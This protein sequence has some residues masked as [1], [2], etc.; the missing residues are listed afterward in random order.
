MLLSLIVLQACS[1]SDFLDKKP[2][3]EIVVANTLTDFTNLL[4]NTSILRN[5]GGLAQMGSDDYAI[6]TFAEWQSLPSNTQRNSYIWNRDIYSGDNG[7]QDWNTVYRGIFYANAVL[8]GL[9]KSPES[10]SDLGLSIK[11]RAL[12]VRSYA[13]YDL[14]RNFCKPYDAATANQDLGIPLRLTAA[15]EQIE[16]R[17]SLQKSFDQI[18]SDLGEAELL[19]PSSRPSS[20]LNRPSKIAVYALLS[21]IYL[22]M[23]KYDLAESNADK[24]LM[25]YNKLIDYNTLSKT[26]TMPFSVTNDE[27]IYNTMQVAT[28]SE[29]TGAG[30]SSVARVAKEL[31]DLY[32]PDDLRIPIYFTYNAMANSYSI[33]RG[34]YGLGLYPFTGLATDEIYLIKAECLARNNKFGPAMDKLN[35]LL[36]KRFPNSVANPYIPIAATSSSEALTK[37]LNER[38][39]EL[40]WRGLRWHDLKRLNKEGAN[41]SLNR[42]LNGKTYSLPPNDPRWI[43]PIPDDE[44]LL[45]GIQQ[46][47]R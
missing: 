24:C 21:R 6:P 32:R 12:F 3:T 18:I 25:L 19:L 41:I 5:T 22:D 14:V 15:I 17:A 10:A 29:T 34:Y 13:F 39:K 27:L 8:D 20:N 2:L 44:I 7:I 37:I 9:K 36:I 31:I 30:P 35:E 42:T 46:N 45:S 43:F 28:Y 16:Q 38:R 23:R 4:E 11:G 26:A 47:L 1:K 40:I 33:K